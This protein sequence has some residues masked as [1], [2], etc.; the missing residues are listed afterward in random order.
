MKLGTMIF[1]AIGLCVALA[2]N[3][4]AQA[5]FPAVKVAAEVG[6]SVVSIEVHSVAY[7][8]LSMGGMSQTGSLATQRLTGFVYNKEGYIAT[9]AAGISE[10]AYIKVRLSDNTELAADF[11]GKD[12]FYGIGVIKVDSPKPL[13]PLKMVREYFNEVDNIYPYD[14]GDAVVAIGNSGGFGGTVT[15]GIISGVRV[16][17]NRNFVLLP[18]MIQADVVINSGNEGCPLF[19]DKGEMIGMHEH[20]ADGGSM[21]N[22][23]FFQPAG[24]VSRVVDEIIADKAAGE[25]IEV[26]HP[27][28]GIKTFA[29]TPS[30]ITGNIRSFS[31]DL[32]MFMDIPDQYWDVGI[33][34]DTVYTESPAREFGILSKDILMAV[35]IL[36]ED[37]SVKRPYTLLK[38]IQDLE[39]MVTT[40]EKGDIFVFQVLRRRKIFDVEVVVD[41]HPGAFAFVNLSALDFQDSRDFF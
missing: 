40:A 2:G 22:T 6:A 32:K 31:D 36:R 18:S 30:I 17:R 27:W 37:E 4:L 15:Y 25:D 7:A 29:G 13:V 1:A 28:L 41:Q 12:D 24:L 8:S 35:T 34:V 9:D 33:A 38:D 21:Q 26:W 11:I 39:I 3:A 20:R 14:R 5:D 16:F 23:T 19:N 10:N